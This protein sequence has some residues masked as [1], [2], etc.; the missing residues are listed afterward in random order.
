M[1]NSKEEIGVDGKRNDCD[2]IMAFI[3][4]TVVIIKQSNLPN[5]IY[6]RYF[7]INILI[8]QFSQQQFSKY[9][10]A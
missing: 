3:I 4:I 6:L 8:K 10:V 1:A 2:H 7:I 9:H 5:L